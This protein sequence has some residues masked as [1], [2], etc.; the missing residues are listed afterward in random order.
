VFFDP[1][2]FGESVASL[3]WGG[4]FCVAPVLPAVGMF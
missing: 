4:T 2:Y 3:F 1:V